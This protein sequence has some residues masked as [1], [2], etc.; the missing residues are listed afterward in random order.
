MLFLWRPCFEYP[1]SAGAGPW[2]SKSPRPKNTKITLEVETQIP[3]ENP[4]LTQDPFMRAVCSMF[5]VSGVTL[6]CLKPGS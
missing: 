5:H 6:P 4:S 1:G 3:S 2:Q